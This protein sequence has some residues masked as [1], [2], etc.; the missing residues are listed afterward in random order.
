MRP[1][2]IFISHSWAYTD[3]YDK[4]LDLL[5]SDS[6]FAY[7]DYSVPKD[8]PIHDAPNSRQ[9][10]EAIER[11]MRFSEVVLM[12]AGVYATY[13]RWINAEIDIA[14]SYSHPK[15]ILAIEPWGS[16]RTSQVVKDHADLIVG[17]NASSIIA[18]IRELA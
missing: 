7:K 12:L 2:S 17:W 5:D 14:N 11:Q 18:G 3:A 1:Y 4:L 10:A 6:R 13:S 16:E 8:D 15:P 9:L